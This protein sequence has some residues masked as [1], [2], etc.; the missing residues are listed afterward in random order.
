MVNIQNKQVKQNIEAKLARYFG[1]NPKEATKE[2]MYKAVTM[3][4]KDILTEKRGDF[5]H[6]VNEKGAKRVY[7]MCVEFLM[8]R[9]LKTSVNN[10]G[11]SAEYENALKEFGYTLEDIY[12]CEP[13]A[14]LGNGGLGRLAACF[15][16]SLSSLDYPATGFSICYEYGFFKQM[17][18]DGMQVELPDIWL[19]GGEVW[20]VPRT[21][22]V[23]KVKM[24]GHVR[25]NW[26]DGHLEVLYDNCEEIEAVPYDMM[27]SG[28]D[29]KA[30]SQL[31]LWKARD[32]NSFN[33]KLFTQGQ[34]TKAVEESTNAE[35]I[36]KV[37]Y[38]SDNHI[39]GKLLRLSQQYFLVSASCQSIIRDH[40]AVYGTLDNLPDK[41]AIHINDTHPAMC[42]PELMRI[43]I[44]EYYS[45]TNIT[46]L[47]K[48]R[49]IW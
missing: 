1:C 27:E 43:L 9:S 41:V 34:Y 12:E 28:A 17:I 23:F 40:M 32:I 48:R 30:V 10:L 38:P 33:M 22:R 42:I 19:P 6:E 49:G 26:K 16:D 39:E 20:L 14:G 29:S 24:G 4:V 45:L 36:S 3:T 35:T 47:G 18:V 2:Q 31:R 25:E 44:D 13:D 7:Y 11:L 21:D 8:G 37:L 5:K 15:M 46:I